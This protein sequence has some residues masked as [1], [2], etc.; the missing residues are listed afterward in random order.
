M[1][2]IT[3]DLQSNGWA[4][5]EK[6]RIHNKDAALLVNTTQLIH[7]KHPT[8]PGDIPGHPGGPVEC[9]SVGDNLVQ[10]DHI[11][12]ALGLAMKTRC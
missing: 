3:C 9:G 6:L 4:G 2:Q 7:N 11:L 8:T 10:G 1:I 12:N 5:E